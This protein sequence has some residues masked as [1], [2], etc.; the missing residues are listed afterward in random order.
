M[1]FV[2]VLRGLRKSRSDAKLGLGPGRKARGGEQPRALQ[3]GQGGAIQE[4]ALAPSLH[5]PPPPARD[6]YSTI[7]GKE[8]SPIHTS[9]QS[10]LI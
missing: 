5:S 7:Q 1:D 4:E 2:N 8:S 9:I 6:I 10:E 3:G